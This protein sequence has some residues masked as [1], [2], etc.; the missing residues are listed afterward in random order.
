[1]HRIARAIS[2][3]AFTSDPIFG[4]LGMI[5]AAAQLRSAALFLNVSVAV[6]VGIRSS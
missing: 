1:M 6:L 5:S 4:W 3:A 2:A